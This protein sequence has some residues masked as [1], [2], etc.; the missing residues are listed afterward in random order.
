MSVVLETIMRR[1]VT[2]KK[3][4]EWVRDEP[5]EEDLRHIQ[6]EGKESPSIYDELDLRGQMID[7]L[8]AGRAVL[9]T[10]RGSASSSLGAKLPAGASPLGMQG[11]YAKVLAIVY[12]DTKIPWATFGKIFTAFGPPPKSGA[13]WRIVWFAHPKKREFPSA[14]A[15]GFQSRSN[16]TNERTSQV[17][18]QHINGGY[19]YA[20]A[21]ETIVIYREEEVERV[22]IHELLHAACTDNMDNPEW[23]REVLTETW[24]ELFL[25]AI[26]ANGSLRKAKQLW[27]IQAQ[28]IANQQ[29]VL[30]TEYGVLTPESF[31][32]RYTVGRASA[33][34]NLGIKLPPPS[35]QP[36]ADLANSLRFTSPALL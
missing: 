14:N 23:L 11:S 13:P 17:T 28:W 25:V 30:T 12:P 1:L 15:E 8:Q 10:W 5:T 27:K 31:P 18:P 29:H 34:Q 2:T 16:I 9:K 33:L 4:F 7:E 6:K 22:L 35:S 26:L 36:R 3:P 24:A 21:P 20:C 32:W 19:A